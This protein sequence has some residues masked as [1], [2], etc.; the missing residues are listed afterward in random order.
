MI[1]TL[2]Y[3]TL[4]A[5]ALALLLAL[6]CSAGAN[7]EETEL[8]NDLKVTA[9]WTDHVDIFSSAALRLEDNLSVLN[10]VS[11]QLGLN[12]RP[13]PSLTFSPNYQ[14]IAHDPAEDVREHEH[15]PGVGAA[16]RIPVKKA[17]VTLSTGVEYRFRE[18]K[19][20]SWRVRPKLKLK[21]P[22]GPD[23]WALSGYVAD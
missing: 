21:Y 5:L 2:G 22:F 18:E 10:R 13:T 23:R 14:Y 16:V 12:L 9:K 6:A 8:W 3:G 1:R 4:A 20:D 19:T 17:E 11:A 7:G 15:R